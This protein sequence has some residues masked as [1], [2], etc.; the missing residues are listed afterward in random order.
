ML[1]INAQ[2]WRKNTQ[3]VSM[4]NYFCDFPLR[5]KITQLSM[6]KVPRIYH[7]GL[8]NLAEQSFF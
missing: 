7:L 4:K 2:N 6:K 1:F 5:D 8:I 3:M